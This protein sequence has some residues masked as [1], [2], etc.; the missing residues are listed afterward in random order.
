MA[1]LAKRYFADDPITCLMKL[2]QFGELLARQ[3]GARVGVSWAWPKPNPT[4]SSNSDATP[5]THGMSLSCFMISGGS[6][7]SQCTIIAAITGQR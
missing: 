2:R 5:P 1:T 6:A 4:C 3:V 7:T